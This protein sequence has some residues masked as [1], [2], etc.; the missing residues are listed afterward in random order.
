MLTSRHFGFRKTRHNSEIPVR[1]RWLYPTL[2]HLAFALML[3]A[4]SACCVFAQL[5][6]APSDTNETFVLGGTVVN[7][8]TGE[9]IARAMVRANGPTS[10]T[11]FSDSEGHFQFEGLPA[12][13]VTLTAQ[14][15]GY[16]S[17]QDANGYPVKA[18]VVGRNTGSLTVKLQPMSSISGRVT[19]A[20]GQPI[21]R[22]VVRLSC[23]TLR[24]GRKVWEP[25]G[26]NETDEDGHFRFPV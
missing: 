5:P 24:D 12:G 15:P 20:V 4:A 22:I 11:G 13:Q 9:G 6:A 17:E 1:S 14:K 26:M 8:V 3:A 19:D 23:R 2:W 7:S 18:V 10:R 21:E 16:Y 25:R